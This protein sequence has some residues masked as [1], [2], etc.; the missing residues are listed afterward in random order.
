LLAQIDYDLLSQYPLEPIYLSDYSPEQLGILYDYWSE[1]YVPCM[2]AHSVHVDPPPVSREVFIADFIEKPSD[3][4]WPTDAT[5][6]MDREA[7]A[8]LEKTCPAKPPAKYFY[9]E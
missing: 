5:A 7:R 6:M 1:Y 2:N 8:K 3:R 4:W 9:G